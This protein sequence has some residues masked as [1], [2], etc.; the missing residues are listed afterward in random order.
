MSNAGCSPQQ[1]IQRS[2]FQQAV[3]LT[4]AAL[5]DPQQKQY[6][7][8]LAGKGSAWNKALSVFMKKLSVDQNL[9]SI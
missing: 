9:K 5:A 2:R 3:S 1:R 8:K 4:K 6:F 7:K